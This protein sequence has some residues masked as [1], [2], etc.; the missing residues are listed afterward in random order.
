M[1]LAI[2]DLD[3]VVADSTARF[4]EAEKARQAFLA[5]NA[6]C[7]NALLSGSSGKQEATNLYWQTA[8]TPELVTL[9]KLVEGAIQHIQR[10]ENN[11]YRVVFLTSRPE[12]MREATVNWMYEQGILASPFVAP[13][14]YE[15]VMKSSA[16]QYT[17]TTVW[18]AGM[19]QTLAG[20]YGYASRGIVMIDDE[21]ANCAEALKYLP[22]MRCFASLAE[23][24][25]K[26]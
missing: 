17:K 7:M 25:E 14:K 6:A 11:R 23:A 9:D 8:F 3:G 18:K 26:L 4:A 13:M 15:L 21:E 5:D 16:F 10:L 22:D 2:I 20:L 12:S 19:T 1:K 24:I